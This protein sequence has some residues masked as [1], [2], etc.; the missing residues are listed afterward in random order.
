MKKGILLSILLLTLC[1]AA[2]I[3]AYAEDAEGAASL[4]GLSFI[5][6]VMLNQRTFDEMSGRDRSGDMPLY[7]IDDALFVSEED[8]AALH[9]I[10]TVRRALQESMANK[11]EYILEGFVPKTE[12]AILA[13]LVRHMLLSAEAQS[14]GYSR[15]DLQQDLM[16]YMRE[17]WLQPELPVPDASDALALL[18]Q[19]LMRSELWRQQLSSGQDMELPY[20]GSVALIDALLEDLCVKYGI[21][22]VFT[23]Q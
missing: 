17:G 3:P 4:E 18:Q 13:F 5:E 22:N 7:Q 10:L 20:Q 6:L 15:E 12:E 23:A 19:G 16:R 9:R 8:V 11:D 1:A 21:P 2:C 14:M